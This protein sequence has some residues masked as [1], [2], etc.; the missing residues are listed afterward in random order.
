[1]NYDEVRSKLNRKQYGLDENVVKDGYIFV[2]EVSFKKEGRHT[3]YFIFPLDGSD[4][5]GGGRYRLRTSFNAFFHSRYRRN[6]TEDWL[7]MQK[8]EEEFRVSKQFEKRWMPDIYHDVPFILCSD[9]WE[10]YKLIGY[11]KKTKKFQQ[12]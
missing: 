7:Y 1:M 10:F 12:Q 4:P 9:L 2:T 5:A 6:R 8:S 11:D 3:R